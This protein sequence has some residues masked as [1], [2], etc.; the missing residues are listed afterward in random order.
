MVSIQNESLRKSDASLPAFLLGAARGG[1]RGF[2]VVGGGLPLAALAR[3]PLLL[4]LLRLLLGLALL[5]GAL[6]LLLLL[7]LVVFL[8]DERDEGVAPTEK[9]ERN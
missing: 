2:V 7:D 3:G 6:R 8:L 1:R 4:G 9:K 5:L